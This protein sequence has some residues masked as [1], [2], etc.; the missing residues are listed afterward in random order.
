MNNCGRDR[1]R[2][3]NTVYDGIKMGRRKRKEGEI[4]GKK[5]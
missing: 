4:E 2:K 1:E 3:K 5:K